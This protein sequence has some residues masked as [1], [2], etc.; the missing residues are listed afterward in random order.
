M[1][2]YSRLSCQVMWVSHQRMST[3]WIH[4]TH[5]VNT[6]FIWCSSYCAAYVFCS[7][8]L[9]SSMHVCVFVSVSFWGPCWIFDFTRTFLPHEDI[10][11][12]VVLGLRTVIRHVV[13]TEMHVGAHRYR[14][15]NISMCLTESVLV[16]WTQFD[17]CTCCGTDASL[18]VHLE[19]MTLHIHTHLWQSPQFIYDSHHHL[20]LVS[21]TVS[22][23]VV[24]ICHQTSL[25]FYSRS[26]SHS[27]LSLSFTLTFSFVFL[28]CANHVATVSSFSVFQLSTSHAFFSHFHFFLYSEMVE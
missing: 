14:N 12:R 25:P 11:Q 18:W 7:F 27:F 5:N 3:P 17:S 26:F 2:A 21:L 13:V 23:S 6:F 20:R 1:S 28:Y 22:L 8:I 15:T 4:F 10:F 9:A 16:L 24:P 19:F